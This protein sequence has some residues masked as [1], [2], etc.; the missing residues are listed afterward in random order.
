MYS[1]KDKF[2]SLKTRVDSKL[3]VFGTKRNHI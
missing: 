3:E 1:L 2:R